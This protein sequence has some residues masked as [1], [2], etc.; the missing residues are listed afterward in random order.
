MKNVRVKSEKKD[1]IC[2]KKRS[3]WEHLALRYQDLWD[4]EIKTVS[5]ES[6]IHLDI[7]K[8]KIAQPNK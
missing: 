5:V 2:K 3:I 8:Q 7:V 4:I 1:K 6:E